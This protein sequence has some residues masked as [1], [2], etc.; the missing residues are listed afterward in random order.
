[1]DASILIHAK[2]FAIHGTGVQVMRRFKS[3]SQPL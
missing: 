2:L 1:M 3:D